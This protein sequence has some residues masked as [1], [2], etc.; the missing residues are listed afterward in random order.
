MRVRIFAFVR[1]ARPARPNAWKG[2]FWVIR[3][4]TVFFGSFPYERD[5]SFHLISVVFP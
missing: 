2:L 4:G 3:S 5:R 1:L